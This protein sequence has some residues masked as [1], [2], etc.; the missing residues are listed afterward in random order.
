M[1]QNFEIY[2]AVFVLTA[3][4]ENQMSVINHFDLDNKYSLY[5][6]AKTGNEPANLHVLIGRCSI[7]AAHTQ[8]TVFLGKGIEAA[9]RFELPDHVLGQ[10][11]PETFQGKK[12]IITFVPVK[13]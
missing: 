6:E 4:R 2:P 13:N 1:K 12:Y 11:K 5:K 9:A 3:N 10:L 7:N 8:Y